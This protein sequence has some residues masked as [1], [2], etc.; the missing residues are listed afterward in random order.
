MW[1]LAAHGR[2]L[3]G[4]QLSGR[5]AQ[6]VRALDRSTD[7]PLSDDL[8][9]PRF[10][11]LRHVAIETAHGDVAHLGGQLGGGERPVA[12]EGLTIRR[13]TGWRR[14]GSALATARALA[15]CSHS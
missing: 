11:E 6:G 9:H 2:Y 5:Q 12:E 10:G 7:P 4:R 1:S 15:Y 3:V 14:R 13:R 8:Q